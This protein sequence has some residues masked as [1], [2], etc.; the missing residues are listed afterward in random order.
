MT[1]QADNLKTLE[2]MTEPKKGSHGSLGK[3]GYKRRHHCQVRII[4]ERLQPEEWQVV[5]A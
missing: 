1:P 4:E 2:K 5:D 3:K